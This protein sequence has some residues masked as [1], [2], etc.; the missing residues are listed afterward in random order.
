MMQYQLASEKRCHMHSMSWWL[1][2]RN[3]RQ[4]LAQTGCDRKWNTGYWLWHSWKMLIHHMQKK[5]KKKGYKLTSACQEDDR[6]L[7]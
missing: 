4:L 1:L 7:L 2:L 5:K 3:I 6:Y